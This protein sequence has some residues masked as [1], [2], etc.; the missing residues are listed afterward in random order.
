MKDL[1]TWLIWLFVCLIISEYLT[2]P[3]FILKDIDINLPKL[4]YLCL[5]FE[6]KATKWTADILCRLTKLQTLELYVEND[7]FVPMF[8]SQLQQKCKSIK[9]IKI[10]ICFYD[11][12]YSEINLFAHGASRVNVSL[13]VNEQIEEEESLFIDNEE[14]SEED[15]DVSGDEDNDSSTEIPHFTYTLSLPKWF[16]LKDSVHFIPIS[17]R[18]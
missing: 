13:K 5:N 12:N 11:Y 14:N 16:K 18:A 6:L 8:V 17:L 2:L 3:E 7:E 1:K 4:Q 9:S 15:Y 10:Y